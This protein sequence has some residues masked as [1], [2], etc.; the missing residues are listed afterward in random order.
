MKKLTTYVI[1]VTL[2]LAVGLS[3]C[4]QQPKSANS[5]EAIEHAKTLATAEEQAKFL[6]SE[7]NAFI[8]SK[9]FDEAIGAAKYVL[10]KLDKESAEAKGIIEQAKA[11]LEEMARQKVEEAKAAANKAAEDAKNK[12]QSLG[13]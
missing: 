1:A 2:M 4:A 5:G 3:G 11:K 10:S 7:A 6:I 9:Q 12:L 8:N 13:K